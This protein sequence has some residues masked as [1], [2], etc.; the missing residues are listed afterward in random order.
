MPFDEK[1]EVVSNKQRLFIKRERVRRN[2]MH[3]KPD[4][5]Y[6]LEQE[7]AQLILDWIKD[8]EKQLDELGKTIKNMRKVAHT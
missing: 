5:V 1:S 7:D 8:L 2:L 6:V 4:L 3:V